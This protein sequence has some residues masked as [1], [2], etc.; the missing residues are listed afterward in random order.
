MAA[1]EHGMPPLDCT[2]R[3]GVSRPTQA[4]GQQRSEYSPGMASSRPL[5]LIPLIHQVTHRIGLHI[6]SWSGLAVT[7]PEAHILDSLAVGGP[8]TVG[9]L[10]L[11]FA[12]RRSTLT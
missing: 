2:Q 9:T 7:P 12:H 1:G 11:A 4:P 6:A 10:H 3:A 8:C 5:Q